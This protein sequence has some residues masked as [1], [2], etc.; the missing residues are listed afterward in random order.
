MNDKITQPRLV[1][2]LSEE[3]GISKRQAEEFIKAFVSTLSD[4]IAGHNSV[5]VKG[6]GSFKVSR[7]DARKS[8]NVSTGEA[9]E[10]PPHFKVSFI[11]DKFVASA[12]NAPFDMFE[13][14]ELDDD[15]NEEELQK[16][17]EEEI[18]NQ[19]E[20][21][22]SEELGEKLEEEFGPIAPTDPF[23]P[24]DPDN[25]VEE[26]VIEITE[27]AVVVTEVPP[28]F[29]D[30]K[31]EKRNSFNKGLLIGIAATFLIMILGFGALYF[32]MMNKLDSLWAQETDKRNS[33]VV[34][35]VED[36]VVPD[37]SNLRIVEEVKV[38]NENVADTRVSDEPKYDTITKTRYLTTMAKE[39]YGN[40]HLWPYIYMENAKILGHPDR[41]KPGTKVVIPELSK[42]HVSATNPADIKKAKELGVQIY[43]KYN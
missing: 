14:V 40:Y 31:N 4:E 17:G 22:T 18:V 21:E 34:I 27:P 1:S 28:A 6:F 10:I 9:V 38:K 12:V 24:V 29:P 36:K 26:K 11:P 8:V 3:C 25:S 41:I 35:K 23:G 13:T 30:I 2:Q 33:Q 19:D 42:Y 20:H 39:Y 16:V 32:L 5:K 43:R 7:M 15:I 37:S